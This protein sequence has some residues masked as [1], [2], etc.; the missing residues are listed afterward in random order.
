MADTVI[1][2]AH[3]PSFTYIKMHVYS[4]LAKFVVEEGN[5]DPIYMYTTTEWYKHA[6]QMNKVH[7]YTWVAGLE[8]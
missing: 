8:N 3:T 7:V 6:T 1:N 4:T 2:I 5:P